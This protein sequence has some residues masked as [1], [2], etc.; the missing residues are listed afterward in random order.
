MI[1][2]EVSEILCIMY[3]HTIFYLLLCARC[4]LKLRHMYLVVYSI[5]T[6]CQIYQ[7]LSKTEEQECTFA[8]YCEMLQHRPSYSTLQTKMKDLSMYISDIAKTEISNY[9]KYHHE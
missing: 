3:Y 7:I 2:S 9:C 4:S 5:G 8:K 6:L 1:A